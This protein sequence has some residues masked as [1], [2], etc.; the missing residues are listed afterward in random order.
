MSFLTWPD[1][2]AKC[3]RS[4]PKRSGPVTL[5]RYHRSVEAFR[6]TVAGSTRPQLGEQAAGFDC[7]PLSVAGC[8]SH[9]D[10]SR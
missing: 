4:A 2:A 10:K 9:T 5:G 7:S 1:E 6:L 3:C 8:R